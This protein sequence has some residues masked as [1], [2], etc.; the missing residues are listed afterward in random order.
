LE[1]I[2]DTAPRTPGILAEGEIVSAEEAAR[3]CEAVHSERAQWTRRSP[4]YPFFTLGA[5]CYLDG[6]SIGYAAYQREAHRLN[7]ILRSRFGWLYDRLQE[8]VSTIVG[9]PASYD[10]RVA[11]P[12]FHV[13]LTEP[14]APRHAG[15]VHYDLQY[16]QID[17]NNWG[18]PDPDRQLSMTIAFALPSAGGGL[19]V[20][21]L[22]R[23]ELGRMGADERRAHAAANRFAQFHPY[24]VGRLVIHSGHQLHQIAAATDPRPSDERITMQAHAIPVD[25]RWLIYW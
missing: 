12:G 4:S 20:W 25:G 1:D 15:S 16:E 14:G 21:N 6:P 17:W 11:L 5:A 13:F 2:M 3:V 8:Y 22:N 24:S 19:L 18:K 9:S 10:D 7:P 23:L